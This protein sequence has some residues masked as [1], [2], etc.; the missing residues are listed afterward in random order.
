MKIRREKVKIRRG[1]KGA[2]NLKG[3]RG[4]GLKIRRGKRGKGVGADTHFYF[5]F[6]FF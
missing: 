4:W 6:L 2:E 1:E 5:L 3:E